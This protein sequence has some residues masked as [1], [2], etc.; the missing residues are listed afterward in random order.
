[1][2]TWEETRD[3]LTFRRNRRR[4]NC[5]SRNVQVKANRV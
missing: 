3:P 1:V 4:E 5:G 2:K